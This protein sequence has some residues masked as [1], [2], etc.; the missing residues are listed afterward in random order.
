MVLETERLVLRRLTWADRAD[1]C[2]ILQDA[3]TMYAY[4][5]AFSGDEVDAWLERQLTRYQTDGVGLWAAVEKARGAFVGQAGITLQGW[6]GRMVPEIGY[7]LKRTFWHRGYAAEAARGCMAYGFDTLEL[8]ALYSIIRD[9]NAA[10]RRVA[11]R[12]G[13]RVVGEQVKH[14]LGMDMHHLVYRITRGEFEEKKTAPAGP[15]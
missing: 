5:H 10:S 14:Y 8:E 2:D 15:F 4:E 3:G 6:D 11:G 7:L 9:N 12:N 1:L 13:M